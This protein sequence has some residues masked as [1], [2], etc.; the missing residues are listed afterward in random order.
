MTLVMSDKADMVVRR[1]L[2]VSARV[3]VNQH[4]SLRLTACCRVVREGLGESEERDGVSYNEV[5][6]I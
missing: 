3:C 5:H 4:S 2:K 6:S 1:G